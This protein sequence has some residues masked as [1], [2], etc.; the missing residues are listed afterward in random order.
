MTINEEKERLFRLE[1]YIEL[2]EGYAPE[3]V[4]WH[5]IKLYVAKVLNELAVKLFKQNSKGVS[6]DNEKLC[7]SSPFN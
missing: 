2:I 5:A 7:G 4:E 3:T 1:A 6:G